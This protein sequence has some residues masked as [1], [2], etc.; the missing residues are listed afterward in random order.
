MFC[1]P[2]CL[3]FQNVFFLHFQ[4]VVCEHE[5]GNIFCACQDGDNLNYFAYITKDLESAKHY[6][7]VFCVKS[8]VRYKYYKMLY[9]KYFWHILEYNV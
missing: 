5:I 6:C 3:N 1:F 4:K 9:Y 2:K 8:T 7:H